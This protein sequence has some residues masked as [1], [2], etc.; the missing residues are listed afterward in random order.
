VPDASIDAPRE[1]PAVAAVD[2]EVREDA[3]MDAFE[4]I[5]ARLFRRCRGA[6]VAI[7]VVNRGAVIRG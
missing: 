7:S 3:T 1:P 2:A 4:Q 5:T 6:A